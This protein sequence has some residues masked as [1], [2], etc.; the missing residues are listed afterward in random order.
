[1]NTKTV[2][3]IINTSKSYQFLD[4][5][6][7]M[8]G[9]MKDVY[10]SPDKSYVV[11]FY[12][13][14]QDYNS[15]ERLIKIVTQY[16][17]SFFNKEGGAYYKDLYSWPT[18]VVTLDKKIGIVVPC[19]NR[20]FFFKKGYVNN[21]LL[22]GKEKEGKWFASAKF[23]ASKSKSKLDDS[24]LGNW[25]SYF[26]VCVNIARGVKRLHA[27]GLA[28]SDLSY[29]NVLIDP[30]SK[31]AA[32]IDI[33]G[34]VVPGLFPP[35]VIGTADFIA[36]EVLSTKHLN[37]NDPNRKLPNRLTDL[38]ALAVLIYMY[39]LY[40]HPLKGGN[41]FGPIDEMEE[42]NLLMGSKS[43]FIEHPTD[44]SNQ[45]FKRE[46]GDDLIKFHPWSDIKKTPYTITGPY[47]KAL[48]DQAFIKGLHNPND[49]PPAVM[50]EEALIKTNDLKLQCCNPKCEQKWFIYNNTKDTFCPFCGS[51]Y[52]HSIP[53][54]DFFY[55]FKTSV[56]KTDNQRLVVYNNCTL[57]QWHSNRNMI[58]TEKLTD[59][60]K[61]RVGY[62]SFYNNKWV[63]VNE[64]LS[65]LK[66]V[67]EDK[68]VPIGS[69]VEIA[70]GKRLL[71]SKE[72]GGRVV[73]VSIANI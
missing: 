55:Q 2:T 20:N 27:A 51:K 45:N 8:R 16:Y 49:R 59:A 47:L 6:E 54:L 38:H 15:K 64:S 43:L 14:P 37:K 31:T 26:Q 11:A 60:Q 40:R 61:V 28:H 62:F 10:F 71:L 42:E 19:Y 5:G 34:L 17:D 32:I 39:L 21:D 44:K 52:T 25:L 18:D 72:D 48:F 57:H 66:D 56:W 4:N 7:P 13:D 3:S 33:D 30:V 35:D 53:V 36:P 67:T 69:M 68:Q 46:Y 1:M 12:R 65:S 24:E 63:F 73:I 70:D 22:K 50:W 58:R 9:G 29:K 41:Y 23:R